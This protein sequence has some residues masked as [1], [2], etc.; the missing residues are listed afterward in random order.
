MQSL[1]M[2]EKIE[3]S[4]HSYKSYILPSG[5][6]INIQGYENYALDE[7][8][9]TYTEDQIK[10]NRRDQP[11]IWYTDK[12]GKKHRYFSD[13]YIPHMNLIIEVKSTWTYNKGLRQGKLQLQRDAC[14][15]EGYNYKYM[16][17][18]DTGK[19]F[20]LPPPS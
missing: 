18:T 16:I 15:D 2:Q 20:I 4:G 7:L 8:L 14:I 3:K 11:E 9:K 1:E 12:T 10:T 17:Y 13:I 5:N 19:E 6:V